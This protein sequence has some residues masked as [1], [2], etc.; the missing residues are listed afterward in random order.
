MPFAAYHELVMELARMKREGFVSEGV[1]RETAP[2]VPN[3]PPE[4]EAEIISLGV[5]PQT[6]RQLRK[7]SWEMIRAGM[8]PGDIALKIKAGEEVEL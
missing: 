4:I 7:T 3:L 2:E 1:S 8:A 6:E 5:E